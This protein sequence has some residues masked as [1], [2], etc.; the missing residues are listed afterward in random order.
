MWNVI[1]I[2]NKQLLN[3]DI[4]V[5]DGVHNLVGGLYKKILMTASHNKDFD[6]SSNG[7]VRVNNWQEA[8]DKIIEYADQILAGKTET[9]K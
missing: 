9:V 4:L 5:D 8:Y 7:M 6:A 2:C 3:A 1:T